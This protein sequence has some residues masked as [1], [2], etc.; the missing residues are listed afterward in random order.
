MECVCVCVLFS[1]T[2]EQKAKENYKAILG[3]KIKKS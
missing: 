2:Q 1:N 3:K